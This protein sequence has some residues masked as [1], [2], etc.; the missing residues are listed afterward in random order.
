MYVCV[1][2]DIVDSYCLV[3][4]LGNR[5]VTLWCNRGHIRHSV[6]LYQKEKRGHRSLRGRRCEWFRDM[7]PASPLTLISPAGLLEAPTRN[8]AVL[9]PQYLSTPNNGRR[10]SS[11]SALSNCFLSLL[12]CFL[13]EVMNGRRDLGDFSV[14]ADTFMRPKY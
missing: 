10:I 5:R 11:Q 1:W 6:R 8:S 2:S 3:L 7:G 14:V 9:A 12:V 13:P 4:L